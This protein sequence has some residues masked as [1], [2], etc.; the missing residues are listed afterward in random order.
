MAIEHLV[1]YYFST[2]NEKNKVCFRE[3]FFLKFVTW[4]DVSVYTLLCD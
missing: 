4:G 3:R 1:Y 2:G